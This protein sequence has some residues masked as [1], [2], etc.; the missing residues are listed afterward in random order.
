LATPLFELIKRDV[1]FV[2]NLDYQHAFEV[3]KRALIAIPVLIQPSFKKPFCFAINW[4][5][6]GVS[7]L[8][9]QKEG[10]FERMVA[11]ANKSLTI[12]QRKFHPMEGNVMH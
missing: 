8:L 1:D 11:Y 2:W 5:P 9:F 12:A 3:L 7:A 4:S 10:K 6:K